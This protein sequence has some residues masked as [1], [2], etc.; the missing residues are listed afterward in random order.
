MEA[1]ARSLEIKTRMQG[2]RQAQGCETDIGARVLMGR[3]NVDDSLIPCVSV[4]E[5]GDKP[6]HKGPNTHI[7]SAS[8][9]MLFAFLPC[10]PDDPNVAAH[11]AIRDIKRAIFRTDGKPSRTWGNKVKDVKYVGCAIGARNDGA[12]F[13]VATV[14]IN[15]EAVED[16]ANP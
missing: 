12:A 13:V 2:I 4:V 15:V 7:E 5:P 16:L 9:F 6:Q 8:E 11:A 10:D 14:K 3:V 1:Y